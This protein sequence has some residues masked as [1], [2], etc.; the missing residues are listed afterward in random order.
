[1]KRPRDE[2][3]RASNMCLLLIPWMTIWIAVAINDTFGAS[4]GIIAAAA[5]SILQL[6]FRPVSYEYISIA[7]VAGLS[8][9]MLLGAD[10][11]IVLPASYAA[12]GLMWC[13]SAFMKIPL[14]ACYSAGH[15]GGEKAFDNL[16]FLRTNRILTAAWGLLYIVTP[17]WTYPLLGTDLSAYTGLINSVCPILMGV[18]TVWFQK[19]Y[20]ARFAAGGS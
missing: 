16:L 8:P 20:P 15:Y 3:R 4:A 9:A 14:T 10:A 7:A 1:M 6:F 18:F 13:A 11:R 12:F 17:I 2:K 5:V 19:W